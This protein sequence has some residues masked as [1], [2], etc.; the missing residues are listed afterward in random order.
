MDMTARNFALVIGIIYLAV[1]VLGFV[2][3]LISPPPADA[4]GIAVNSFHGYL[5]GLFP[6]NLMH[7]LVHLAIGAWG[8][9]AARS[10]TGARTYSK[11][12]AIIYGILAVMGLI[13]ALNTVFGLVPIHGHD[14]WLHAVT[15]IIAAYFGW[16]AAPR[17]ETTTRTA[18]IR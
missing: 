10:M 14:V 2:P 5:L 16:V 7:N 3:P 6:I 17:T 13:P 9:A 1:G 18:P 15:A 12:L 4:P 11:A 8:I